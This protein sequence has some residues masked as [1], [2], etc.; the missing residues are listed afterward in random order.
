MTLKDVGDTLKKLY[1]ADGKGCDALLDVVE[2]I[3]E[4]LKTHNGVI[5]EG[6]TTG[7]AHRVDLTNVDVFVADDGTLYCQAKEEFTIT[8]EEHKTITLPKG[9]YKVRRVQEFDHFAEEARSVKD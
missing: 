5:A 7:H 4:N 9:N 1:I 3:P 2:S 8:H 6:E